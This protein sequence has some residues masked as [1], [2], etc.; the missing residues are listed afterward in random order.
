MLAHLR[1]AASSDARHP[2]PAV[3]ADWFGR[4]EGAGLDGVMAKPVA[5]VYEPNKRT[6][7]KVKHERDCD[8]VVAGFRWHKNG[9]AQPWARCCLGSTTTR[10]HC[11]TWACA[12]VSTARNAGAGESSSRRTAGRARQS[13]VARWAEHSTA[14]RGAPQRMPGGRSRWSQRQGP[15]LGAAAPELVVEVA[16]EH[17]QGSALPPHGA[18]ST[19]APLT[20]RRA[21]ARTPSS[22]SSRR[23]S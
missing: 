21:T 19:L 15:V 8:C 5:G 23:K 18:V 12:P 1:A 6:M 10:A 4:F 13:P 2:T 14:A 16:Y 20:N 11:S 7:L 3:A 9:R 22:K 17:M